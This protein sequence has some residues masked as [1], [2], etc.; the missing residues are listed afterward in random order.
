MWCGQT[1]ARR[2]MTRT[3]ADDNVGGPE[4]LL[5]HAAATNP[6]DTNRSKAFSLGRLGPRPFPATGRRSP[7]F[8]DDQEQNKQGRTVL[9]ETAMTK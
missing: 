8:C 6:I 1:G 4:T 5:P 3:K 7:T 2:T 9:Q